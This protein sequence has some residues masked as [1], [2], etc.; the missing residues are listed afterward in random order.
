VQ[1]YVKSLV[2]TVHLADRSAM[3]A[4]TEREAAWRSDQLKQ[5]DKYFH[6]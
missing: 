5:P 2:G 4:D 1:F 6:K 3:L